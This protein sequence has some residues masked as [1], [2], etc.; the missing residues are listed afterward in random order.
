MGILLNFFDV[1]CMYY[2]F[3]LFGENDVDYGIGYIILYE[4]FFV[5]FGLLYFFK[6]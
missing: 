4:Y 1:Y 3:V 6:I 2:Q 5:I